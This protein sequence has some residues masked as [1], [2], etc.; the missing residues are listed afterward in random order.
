MDEN[1]QVYF[2]LLENIPPEDLERYKRAISEEETLARPVHKQSAEEFQERLAEIIE[3]DKG[4]L[5]R[6]AK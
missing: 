4:L 5:E 3:Q 1:S 6:L 2:D